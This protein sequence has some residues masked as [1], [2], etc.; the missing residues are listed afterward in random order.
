MTFTSAAND[1]VPYDVH[2]LRNVFLYDSSYDTVYVVSHGRDGEPTE[3]PLGSSG[4]TIAASSRF[5]VFASDGRNIAR[6][7]EDI[8]QDLFFYRITKVGLR[9]P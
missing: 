8:Y 4:S 7:D 2:Y 5:V 1:L 3:G 6:A 9:T